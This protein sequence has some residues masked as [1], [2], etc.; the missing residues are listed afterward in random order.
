MLLPHQMVAILVHHKVRLQL[1]PPL[2]DE[3]VDY[4][5]EGA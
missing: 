5:S 4:L 1:L 3:H 2:E